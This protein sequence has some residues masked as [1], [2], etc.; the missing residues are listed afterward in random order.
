MSLVIPSEAVNK[1]SLPLDWARA[2]KFASAARE[3]SNGKFVKPEEPE[4]FVWSIVIGAAGYLLAHSWETLERLIGGAGVLAL[5]AFAALI[6]V[7]VVRARRA[8][9]KTF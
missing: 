1:I 8:A 9:Q 5:A 2:C 4:T 3:T 6:V 7:G